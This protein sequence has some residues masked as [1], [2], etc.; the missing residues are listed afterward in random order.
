MVSGDPAHLARILDAL[1]SNALTFAGEQRWVRARV[2]PATGGLARVEVEDRG[3]GVAPAVAGHIFER[4]Y[5]AR[6]EPAEAGTGLG[7]YIGR[8][9]AT[10]MG[11]E[12]KLERSQ[13]SEGSL[14]VL[15]MPEVEARPSD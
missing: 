1:L 11:A 2:R 9:L 12:L 13:P 7:L 5:R 10:R 4:F 8:Q 6:Q 15:A 14:F 3:L